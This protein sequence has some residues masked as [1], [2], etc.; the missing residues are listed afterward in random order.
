MRLAVLKHAGAANI[1]VDATATLDFAHSQPVTASALTGDPNSGDTAGSL[2]LDHTGQS[3]YVEVGLSDLDSGINVFSAGSSN[4]VKQTQFVPAVAVAESA[5]AFTENN[6]VA[7]TYVCTARVDGVFGYTRSSTGNL[8]QMSISM[9]Q[10]APPITSPGTGYCVIGIA[11]SA[12]GRVAIAWVPFQYA[13]SVTVGNQTYVGIY[14]VNSDNSLT[15][16]PNS[17][18]TTAS[19][20]TLALN[21]DPTGTYLAVAGNGGV[22]TYT[23]TSTGTLTAVAS[24]QDAG[25]SFTSVAW[26]KSNH[27]FATSSSGLYVWNAKN[28]MLSGAAGSPYPGGAGLTVLPLQ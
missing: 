27:V 5:L 13:S 7:Y 14:N 22:Q 9:Q 10:P 18:V 17:G 25:V 12:K 3:L 4:T 21:F 11:A 24:P 6:Q 20:S 26:D 15:L 1:R 8:T 19:T 28:G 16:V 23:L 2:S